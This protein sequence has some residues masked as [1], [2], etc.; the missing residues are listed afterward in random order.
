MR[1]LFFK[2]NRG[3]FQHGLA[4]EVPFF[5]VGLIL[6]FLQHLQPRQLGV[7]DQRKGSVHRLGAGDGRRVGPGRNDWNGLGDSSISGLGARPAATGLD[8]LDFFLEV[9]LAIH[10]RAD[11]IMIQA[12]LRRP[13]H[14]RFGFGAAAAAL[15]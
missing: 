12:V 9:N 8:E 10:Q 3:D 4:E 11:A 2:K 14:G 1:S 15:V 5:Q 7:G 13:A 6:V